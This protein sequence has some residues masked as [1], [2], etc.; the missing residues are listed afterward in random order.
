MSQLQK[1]SSTVTKDRRC[2][3]RTAPSFGSRRDQKLSMGLTKTELIEKYRYKVRL[4]AV[5]LAR[6]LPPSIEVDDLISMGFFGLMDAAD[7]YEPARGIKFDTYAEFRI[8]GAIL[9]GLR[10]QDW[11][12]RNARDQMSSVREA[13]EAIEART[14]SVASP[15][16]MS[17][18]MDMPLEKFHQMM[19]D[20]GSRVLVALDDLPEG[21]E[22][23]ASPLDD[24]FHAAVRKEVKSFVD[25]M[26]EALTEQEKMVLKFYYYRGLN[27][28]E[29]STILEVSESRISQI[30]TQAV[31]SLRRQMKTDSTSVE[32]L[33]LALID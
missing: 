23:E 1:V 31:M 8:R 5:K 24:P 22:P 15:A 10:E 28:K 14:G 11:I 7:K 19:R 2:R 3:A 13:R 29:I 30:H 21:I 27:L 25:R 32:N 12:S 17:K 9:D 6:Q 4:I 20:L 16:E 26:V 33:L 18:E